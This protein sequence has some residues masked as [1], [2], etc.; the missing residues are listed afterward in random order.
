MPQIILPRSFNEGRPKFVCRLC[1]DRQYTQQALARHIRDHAKY[2]PEKIA[3]MSAREQN[4]GI[5]GDEG[6]DV[7]YEKWCRARGM[8]RRD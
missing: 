5:F 6:V 7:E 2:D 3:F 4:P 8:A 1:G